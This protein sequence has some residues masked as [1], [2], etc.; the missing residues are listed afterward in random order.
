MLEDGRAK[1]DSV[2]S[3]LSTAS[4]RDMIEAMIAGERD[5][6]VLARLARGVMRR[7]IPELEMACDGRF[8]DSHAQMCRL[9][10]DAWDHLTVQVAAVDQLVAEAA[11]PFA[12][13]IAR[14]VTIPGIGPRTA[15]VIVEE[16]A[17]TK[18]LAGLAITAANSVR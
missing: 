12:A 3:S 10:L 13:V 6:A 11:A 9:H 8:T 4:A 7:K 15:P 5:P 2:A 14:L 16:L 18:S 1:I 17:D